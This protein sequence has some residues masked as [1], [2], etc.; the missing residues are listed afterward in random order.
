MPWRQVQ[1]VLEAG[2]RVEVVPKPPHSL[3]EFLRQL[4]MLCHGPPRLHALAILALV[5]VD[6]GVR[7]V[8]DQRF[9]REA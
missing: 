3:A 7:Y 4:F 5:L 9:G 1:Y 2:E 6:G 8:D